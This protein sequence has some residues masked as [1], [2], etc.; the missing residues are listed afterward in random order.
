M[1][2]TYLRPN[3]PFIWIRFK[4]AD[5]KWYSANTGFRKDDPKAKKQAKLL[6]KKKSLEE[7]IQ[8]PASGRSAFNE[9]VEPWLEQR[10]GKGNKQTL[11]KYRMWWREWSIYL[12]SVGATSPVAVNREIVL[13][14]VQQREASGT[15][16]NT[17]LDEVSFLAVVLD[18]AIKRDYARDNPARRLGI[19]RIE[20]VHKEIWTDEQIQLA[21]D[22]AEKAERFGFLHTSLLMGKYQA[23]RI[24]SCA[25]PVASI[26]LEHGE[27]RYPGSVMKGGKPF[28]QSIDPS[29]LPTLKL[30]VAHR[31]E[32]GQIRLCNLPANPSPS[33]ELRRFL[34]GI[35]LKGLSHHGLRSTWC[36]RAALRGIPMAVAMKYTNHASEDVHR[37]YEQISAGDVN[38]FFSLLAK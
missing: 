32:V 24:S 14:Y 12:A 37:A 8:R 10:W 18:E 34:D 11:R 5:G 1:A 2:S 33:L 15:S 38:R 31:R 13:A 19:K 17:A 35:G 6:A 29:F 4:R 36:T 20:Q 16:R 22:A 27:I 7:A 26:D 3:S 23:I 28:V 21:L 25:V 30:I 9:W